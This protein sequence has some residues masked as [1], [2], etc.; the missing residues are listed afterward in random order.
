MAILYWTGTAADGNWTNSANWSTGAFP[1]TGDDVTLDRTSDDITLNLNQSAVLL[2]SLSIT[3]SFQGTIGNIPDATDEFLQIGAT[4]VTIGDGTGNGSSRLNLELGT[5]VTTINIINASSTGTDFPKAPLRI[6]ANNASNVIQVNGNNSTVSF[7][8]NTDDTG[9]LGNIDII[10]GNDIQIGSGATYTSLTM[11]EGTCTS[12]ETSGTVKVSAGT[13]RLE[14]TGAISSI[15][16]TGGELIW[17]STG[18]VNS[19]D[20]IGGTLETTDSALARTITTLTKSPGFTFNRNENVTV[21]NDNFNTDFAEFIIS[22][23]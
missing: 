10:N 9:A 22:I 2:S 13:M 6:N 7:L 5:D 23:T 14:G 20:G 4:V 18:T 21:T 12:F 17:N 3:N 11:I 15:I 16:Q 19:Y 1:V 8:D